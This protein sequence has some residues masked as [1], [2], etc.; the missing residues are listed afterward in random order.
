MPK[1]I[2][3]DAR[4]RRSSTGRP[5]DELVNHLQKYD[6]NNTYTIHVQP[7]DDWHMQAPNFTTLPCPFPQ[8]SLNPLHELRFAW[9][10]YRLK[11]DLV[12]FGMTQQPLL[13]FGN[14]VT[15]THDLTMLYHVRRGTMPMPVYWFKM[16][17]YR[18]LLWWGHRK[19]KKIITFAKRTAKE[20][21]ELHPFAKDKLAVI[22]QAPGVAA[23]L[24]SQ[25]PKHDFGTYIM[26]QGTAFPHKN[27]RKLVE[28][29]DIVHEH[30]PKLNLV[31]VGKT[32][33]HY[34]E[35]EDEAKKHPSGA[36]IIF[37]G[38]LPDPESKWTFEHA[39]LYVTPTL[40]EGIGLTPL[41][42]MASGAPVIS[43][44]ASV[45]PEIY[46]PG[47]LYCDGQDPQDIADKI[48][49]VLGDEKLRQDLIARGAKQVKKY[50]WDKMAK[51]TLSVYNSTLN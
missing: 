47:A 21:A 5:L 42:A 27:L 15:Y 26:Y 46:G 9:Q 16:S 20:I 11:P 51:E 30:Y 33:K 17:L 35:I 12:H 29:F 45:M 23:S 43:S 13:Y 32:E 34:I 1:H 25:K 37:T 40:M 10:L 28:A 50:S 48:L 7:D 4:I 38:F 44:D 3:I 18:F 6:H 22:Y 19:S 49:Q 39:R 36:H 14:I 31:M 41:E 24:K 8:F 2:V